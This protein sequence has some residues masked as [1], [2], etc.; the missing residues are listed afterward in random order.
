MDFVGI[1]MGEVLLILVVALVIWGPGRM[2]EVGRTL[3]KI[4]YTL[5]KATSDLT[6]QVTKEIEEQEKDHPL[7]R[8]GNDGGEA[9]QATTASEVGLQHRGK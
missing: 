4:V 6:A 3:G 2:A 1:G 9:G 7:Q 5:K 8:K